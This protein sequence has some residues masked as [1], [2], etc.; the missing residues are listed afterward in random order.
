MVRIFFLAAGLSCLG[1]CTSWPTNGGAASAWQTTGSAARGFRFDWRLSGD[2]AVAPMQVFDDGKEVWLQF[3]PGQPLPA[4]FGM[5]EGL[6]HPLPYTRRE[7]YAVVAGSW[8]ALRF[9]GGRLSARAERDVEASVMLSASASTS[10]FASASAS[11]SASALPHATRSV[12]IPPSGVG[13]LAARGPMGSAGDAPAKAA[14][15]ALDAAVDGAPTES[16]P[17]MA[18]SVPSISGDASAPARFY[19]AAPPDTTLRA[20]LARW[21]GDSGWTF[22]PQHWAVDVDIPLSASAEFSGDFKSAVRE[23]LSATELADKP[24]QPCFYANQVL[25]VVPLAQSC[26]RA[27]VTQ[28]A[29]A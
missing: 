29:G 11:A 25:R 4:I 3:A 12:A 26:S 14:T 6:E 24:L 28:G 13:E 16:P 8:S 1:A 27:A 19:R 10:A 21:A 5:R 20:V 2:P 7:P 9:R 22:R 23:L 17:A 15:T 18:A